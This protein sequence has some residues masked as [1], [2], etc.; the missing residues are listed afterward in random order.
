MT[1]RIMLGT[2]NLISRPSTKMNTI[3]ELLIKKE[4]GLIYLKLL[5]CSLIYSHKLRQLILLAVFFLVFMMSFG[6][7]SNFWHFTFP[8]CPCSATQI[9]R[10]A[11]CWFL[12]LLQP[13]ICSVSD[14]FSKPILPH[15][16]FQKKKKRY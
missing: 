6:S 1:E 13:S 5:P 8:L 15:Y 12:W 11:I 9:Q 10:Y 3:C 7:L 2:D 4:K 16:A 14:K